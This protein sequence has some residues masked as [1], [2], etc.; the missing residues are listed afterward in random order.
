M[1]LFQHSTRMGIWDNY[2]CSFSGEPLSVGEIDWA[3]CIQ[4][5]LDSHKITASAIKFPFHFLISVNIEKPTC[6]STLLLG[7]SSGSEGDV[8]TMNSNLEF[9]PVCDATFGYNEAFAL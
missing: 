1:D 8:M 5:K 7:G 2:Y 9:G 4:G 6:P 3:Q